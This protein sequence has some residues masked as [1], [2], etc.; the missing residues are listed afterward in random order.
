MGPKSEGGN[1]R[2]HREVSA[3]RRYW[4]IARRR[5]LLI[6]ACIVI[7]LAIAILLSATR[8]KQFRGEA[9]VVIDRQNLADSVTGT[10]D[11]AS[12][13]NDFMRIVQ[14]QATIAR[15]PEVARRTVEAVPEADIAAPEL[16]RQSSV[17]PELDADVLNFRV[18]SSDPDLATDL[19][20]EYAYAYVDYR[21]E[22]DTAAVKAARLRLESRIEA[23]ADAGGNEG[24][25]DEL[26]SKEEQLRIREALESATSTIVT[27]GAATQIVPNPTLYVIVALVAGGL[28]AVAAA[29]AREA[30]DTRVRS[31]AE[32]E[33]RLALPVL[34][35]LPPPPRNLQPNQLVSLLAPG[36]TDAEALRVLRTNIS[37]AL[38]DRDIRTIM[39]TS[40]VEQEGK[41]TTLSNL[42]VTLAR[43]GSR[44]AVVDLDL[45][46]PR[47]E[48][49]FA[50]PPGPGVT[51][52]I[53]HRSTLDEALH[54]IPIERGAGSI[55]K[56]S[57]GSPSE[58]NGTR[59]GEVQVLR[60][61][62]IPPDPGEFVILPSVTDLL[63]D[64]R[65]RF[66]FVLVDAPPVLPVGD[67]MSLSPSVDGVFLVVNLQKVRRATL[68]TLHRHITGCQAYILGFVVAGKTSPVDGYEYYG[69]YEYAADPSASVLDSAVQSPQ[70]NPTST[71]H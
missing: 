22:L 21:Q 1:V 9:E 43:S 65:K 17:E 57:N 62:V 24:L 3:L 6:L 46:R 7:P 39:V 56:D 51:D 19:S 26:Q 10:T 64:L 66:D 71:P 47:L 41:S 29:G 2:P 18:T 20:E 27:S 5:K 28:L 68:E 44:V 59:R 45:R 53:L 67:A 69:A 63:K 16:L 40:A 23:L 11:P 8:E 48:K 50:L 58:R 30:L 61:G 34:A 42:A 31:A 36:S 15:S 32:V 38:L 14:T 25:V 55:T 52:V 33:D 54:E 49:L 37:F 12:F 13:A 35:H 4:A 70:R 60:A